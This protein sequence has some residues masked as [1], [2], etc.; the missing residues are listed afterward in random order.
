MLLPELEAAL[1]VAVPHFEHDL[2]RP[3]LRGLSA[4]RGNT[5][6][7][8]RIPTACGRSSS[9]LHRAQ[10]EVLPPTDWIATYTEHARGSSGSFF[11]DSTPAG[12]TRAR[13][14]FAEVETLTRPSKLR[15]PRRSWR[16]APARA[17][18]KARR[19]HRLGRRAARRSRA[20]LFVAPA[21]PVPGLGRRPELRRRAHFYHRLAPCYSVHYGVFTQ[22]PDYVDQAL[23]T[24]G[25]RLPP[26]SI[27]MGKR[28]M[29]R[30]QTP[31][32]R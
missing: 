24:L 17:R 26:T 7:S 27:A 6:R 28:D 12:R 3:A 22:R 16:R 29:P 4:D 9:A 8:T 11:R 20:R 2:A 10:T 18:R 31:T 21:R 15:H 32:I 5:A 19:C 1:P 14:L 30:C 23:A 25:S 13:A